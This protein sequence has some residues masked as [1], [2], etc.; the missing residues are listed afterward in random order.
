MNLIKIAKNMNEAM[1]EKDSWG[2]HGK[3]PLDAS[4]AVSAVAAFV[5]LLI[6]GLASTLILPL[7]LAFAGGIAFRLLHHH[8]QKRQASQK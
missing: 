8:R 1:K 5:A 6:S 3:P 7:T 2:S 4:I